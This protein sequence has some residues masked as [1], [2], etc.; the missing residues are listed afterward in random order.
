MRTNLELSF[1]T[2]KV[3]EHAIKWNDS[4]PFLPLL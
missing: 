4:I 1:P 3:S 2:P